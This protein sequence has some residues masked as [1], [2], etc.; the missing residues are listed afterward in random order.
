VF[1]HSDDQGRGQSAQMSKNTNDGLTRSG[2]DFMIS[3]TVPELPCWQA[4]K[5]HYWEQ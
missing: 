4:D 2:T 5:R 1:G 3:Q